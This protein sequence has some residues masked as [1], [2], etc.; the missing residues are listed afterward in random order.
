MNTE[1]DLKTLGIYS[2]M[3]IIISAVLL[4]EKGSFIIIAMVQL[5]LVM[6]QVLIALI[7]SIVYAVSNVSFPVVLKNYWLALVIYIL[8]GVMGGL[9]LNYLEVEEEI[10]TNTALVHFALAWAVI[11]YHIK[12]VI[13][14]KI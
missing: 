5:L 7:K 1:I 2:I 13:P 8:C 3:P 9:I 4:M 10:I 14:L 6:I 11:L 12:H